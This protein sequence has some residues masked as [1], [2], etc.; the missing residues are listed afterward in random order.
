MWKPTQNH[1][2]KV[3]ANRGKALCLL[4]LD[5]LFPLEYAVCKK[6]SGPS[7]KSTAHQDS[8]PSPAPGLSHF[9]KTES[10]LA[11]AGLP[12]AQRTKPKALVQ[13]V[14]PLLLVHPHPAR[15]VNS[16]YSSVFYGHAALVA[17]KVG[18]FHRILV[19]HFTMMYSRWL[20]LSWLSP[21]ELCY[22]KHY[23]KVCQWAIL[24]TITWKPPSFDLMRIV[25]KWHSLQLLGKLRTAVSGL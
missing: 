2:H 3:L 10:S 6:L 22:E 18:L 24:Q 21:A 12:S 20:G 8:H 5:S 25:S 14:S 15:F 4:I 1:Y 17:S 23:F 13:W 16:S 7:G 9:P 19:V 11:Q